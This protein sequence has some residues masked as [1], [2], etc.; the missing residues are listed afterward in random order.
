MLLGCHVK[1]QRQRR[2]A[3]EKQLG[4]ST[5]Q[6][7]MS[8]RTTPLS[9]VDGTG[10]GSSCGGGKPT[11]A[12][13]VVDHCFSGTAR[14]QQT[15]SNV[16]C[17][18]NGCDSGITSLPGAPRT[19]HGNQCEKLNYA[20]SGRPKVAVPPRPITRVLPSRRDTETAAD[21]TCVAATEFDDAEYCYEDTD[22]YLKSIM[23]EKEEKLV[24]VEW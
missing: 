9:G 1:Q 14:G 10:C 12:V 3:S 20:A 13:P 17:S 8:V 15:V 7:S 11:A 4:D 24:S 5:T 23:K 22:E 19:C 21:A 2:R 18:L 6:G 16:S